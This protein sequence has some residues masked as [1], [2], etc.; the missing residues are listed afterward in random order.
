MPPRRHTC[1]WIW[2][3]TE[4]RERH[5]TTFHGMCWD[6]PENAGQ[7]HPRWRPVHRYRK[8]R[9]TWPQC[10]DADKK[11]DEGD[12]CWIIVVLATNLEVFSDWCLL[13]N[14][15]HYVANYCFSVATR[16]SLGHWSGFSCFPS[17]VVAAFVVL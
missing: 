4:P 10:G 16:F 12:D 8:V 2:M 13:L 11:Q 14:T 3:R 1:V 17:V 6:V 15:F 9:K 7:Q 5:D